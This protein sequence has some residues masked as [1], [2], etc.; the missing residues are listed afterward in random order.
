MYNLK[1]LRS[2]DNV[3]ATRE[4]NVHTLVMTDMSL[5]L[6]QSPENNSKGFA[7]WYSLTC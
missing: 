4:V 3:N 6:R 7:S 2:L 1:K 5:G